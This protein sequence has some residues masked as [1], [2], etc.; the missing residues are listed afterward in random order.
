[1]T[2]KDRT[3]SSS[4]VVL[5]CGSREWKDAAPIKTRLSLLPR[6]SVVIHGAARGADQL[7]GTIAAGLGFEVREFPADWKNGPWTRNGKNL[8]GINRNTLMLDQRPDLVLAYQLNGSTG[9]QHTIDHARK[10]GIETE[11]YTS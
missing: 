4:Y 1:M 8:A 2:Q 6:G 5:V 10:R 11:V 7:A 3:P 9:T